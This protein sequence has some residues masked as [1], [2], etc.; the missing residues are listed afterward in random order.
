MDKSN[1][2][3]QTT[4]ILSPIMFIAIFLVKNGI[5]CI[6]DIKEILLFCVKLFVCAVDIFHIHV[7]SSSFQGQSSLKMMALLPWIRQL[8]TQSEGIKT[9]PMSE[10]ALSR[11]NIQLQR[12]DRQSNKH[13]GG[14]SQ[15]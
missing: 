12:T 13:G 14:F 15:S 4:P 6:F 11:L 1:H 8:K 9:F 3:D 2:L 5:V 7:L 10:L